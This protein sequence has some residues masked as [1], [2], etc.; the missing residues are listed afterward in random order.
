MNDWTLTDGFLRKIIRRRVQ[1]SPSHENNIVHLYALIREA[2]E[3]EFTEDTPPS[4]RAFLQECF[5]K[6]FP[7]Q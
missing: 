3:A 5:D 2:V 1:Q 7:V 6:S 4:I